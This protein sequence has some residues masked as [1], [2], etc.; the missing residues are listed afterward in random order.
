DHLPH[1]S[2]EEVEGT[3]YLWCMLCHSRRRREGNQAMGEQ[4]YVAA[5]ATEDLEWERLELLQ[6]LYDASTTQQLARLGIRAGGQGLGARVHRP[7]ARRIRGPCGPRGGCRSG[8]PLVTTGVPP[9]Q[10]RDPT[11]QHPHPGGGGPAIRSRLLSGATNERAAACSGAGAHG[12]GG[13]A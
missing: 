8:S 2:Q 5:D 6:T 10:Y 11:P 4:L 3:L 12:R 9:I 7:L 13:P 1:V